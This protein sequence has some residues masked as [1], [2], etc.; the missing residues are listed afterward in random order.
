MD[1]NINLQA[2]VQEEI[3]PDLL[4]TALISSISYCTVSTYP[5]IAYATNKSMQYASKLNVSH[6]E[7]VKRII[8]YLLQT[9]E[10]GISYQREGEGIKGYVHNLA[11]FMYADFA[12]NKDD[13]KS[14]SG[15]LFT[16]NSA[17]I[18]WASKKTKNCKQII[19]GI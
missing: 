10:Y 7:A 1:P 3:T 4:Y 15:W 11:G 14:T 2:S 6:W 9:K 5:D 18:S 19:Y 17:P 16:F 13:H 12:G 8:R